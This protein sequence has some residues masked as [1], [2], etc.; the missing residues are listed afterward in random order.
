M[1]TWVWRTALPTADIPYHSEPPDSK[2]SSLWW[3][4]AS[5]ASGIAQATEGRARREGKGAAWGLLP[6]FPGPL[7]PA[8]NLRMLRTLP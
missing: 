8:S 6:G 3:S 1:L 4:A 2:T 7:G 5:S